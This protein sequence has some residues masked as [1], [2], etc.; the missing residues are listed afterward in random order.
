MFAT[1]GKCNYRIGPQLSMVHFTLVRPP[2]HQHIKDST[3]VT[4]ELKLVSLGTRDLRW[5]CHVFLEVLIFFKS[6][7]FLFLCPIFFLCSSFIGFLNCECCRGGS[8]I[9]GFP[10]GGPPERLKPKGV[11]EPQENPPVQEPP[12]M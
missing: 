9:Y 1:L 3:C 6:Q 2:H 4:K 10:K 8:C 12:H 5:L 11:S 7:L